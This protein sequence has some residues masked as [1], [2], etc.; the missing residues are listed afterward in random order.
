MKLLKNTNPKRI[1]LIIVSLVLSGAAIWFFKD[2]LITNYFGE[3]SIAATHQFSTFLLISIS[4]LL[5]WAIIYNLLDYLFPDNLVDWLIRCVKQRRII[6]RHPG[7]MLVPVTQTSHKTLLFALVAA[8]LAI[9]LLVF[10]EWVFLV[11]KESFMDSLPVIEKL[12]ILIQSTWIPA[13]I[14]L[15]VIVVVWILSKLLKY[16]IV[17]LITSSIYRVIPAVIV[18]ITAVLVFDNFTYNILGI[19]IV[20]SHSVFRASY[21]LAFLLFINKTYCKIQ[22]PDEPETSFAKMEI[23]H[24]HGNYFIYRGNHFHHSRDSD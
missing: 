22:L 5:G 17:Q 20:D 10:S 18:A 12:S 19:G 3:K 9:F 16:P 7:K 23:F 21:G 11:T 13:I 2:T 8:Y 1:I 4:A 14:I 24:G 6:F 15:V